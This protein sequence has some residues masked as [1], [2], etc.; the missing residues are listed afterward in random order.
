LLAASDDTVRRWI[1][2]GT[3][4]AGHCSAAHSPRFRWWASRPPRSW[5]LRPGS[6]AV[7]VVEAT[8]VVVETARLG[9]AV[10]SD[11]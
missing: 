4:P 3:L 8:T 9:A 1:N 5:S 6:V 7:G 10:T 2:Q 11:W